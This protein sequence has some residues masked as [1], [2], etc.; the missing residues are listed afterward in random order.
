MSDVMRHRTEYEQ[1]RYWPVAS[2]SVIERGD[3][4]WFDRSVPSVK[5]ASDFTWD[6][7]LETTQR[8]FKKLYA[9][10]AAQKS[11]SGDTDELR[12]DTDG[13]FA[14][15]CASATWEVG[16]KVAPAKAA[17]NALKDQT[18]VATNRVTGAIGRVAYR[19]ASA[20]VEVRAKLESTL[21]SLT[22]CFTTT[23]TTTTTV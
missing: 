12:T 13:V 19:E 7:D 1:A 8:G 15:I 23:T 2:A 3:L 4:T 16:D 21:Q 14:M 20:K 10:V 6:T 9:G 22:C 5:A 11:D 17:G 18:V